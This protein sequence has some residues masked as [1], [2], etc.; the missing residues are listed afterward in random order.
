VAATN[1]V[2]AFLRG[3]TPRGWRHFLL[4]VSLLGSFEIVYALSGIYGR[5]V[6]STAVANARGLLDLE[7]TLGVAWEHGLQNWTLRAPQ[8]FLDIANRT[9]FISQFT[10]STLFLLWVYA[11]RQEHFARA[12]NALLAANYVSVIV[13][14]VYP[15]APPRALVGQGFVDTL[16]ANAVNLHSSVINALN[17]PNSAMPSLHASYAVVLG[18]S[19][20]LL[21]RTVLA[22]VLWA[23][24]PALVTYSVVATGNHFVLDVVA[25]V[26]ALGATPLVDRVATWISARWTARRERPKS[27]MAAERE[28]V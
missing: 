9:Y 20:V 19:G 5:H 6:S 15:L 22:K 26:A 25:G 18:V 10:V 21:T 1:R 17:N 23:C 7:R 2:A 3:L 4:Q 28:S 8:V 27:W 16:D 13:M 11:R 24:Y 14:F 12:R